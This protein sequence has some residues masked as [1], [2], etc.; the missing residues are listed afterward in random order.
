[1]NQNWETAIEFVLTWENGYVNIP[2]DP[3]GETNFGI[4]KK[5]YPNLDIKNLSKEA[6]IG[7]YYKDYWLAAGCDTIWNKMDIAVFDTAVDCGVDEAKR[8]Y[9]ALQD[10]EDWKD[11][12][13][14]RIHYYT[15]LKRLGQFLSGWDDRV[16]DLWRLLKKNG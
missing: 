5:A 7:I 8:L 2:G 11:Y 3:G 15:T 13:F 14:Y 4:S 6:V 10:S 16:V 1:M 9:N 12:L